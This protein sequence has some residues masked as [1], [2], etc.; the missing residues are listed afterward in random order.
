MHV[1][2]TCGRMF[3]REELEDTYDRLMEERKSK[4]RRRAQ[5]I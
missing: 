2:T 1:C 3:T 4:G 5:L